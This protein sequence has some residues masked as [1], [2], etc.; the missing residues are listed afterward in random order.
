[1]LTRAEQTPRLHLD[2]AGRSKQ[3]FHWLPNSCL[4]PPPPPPPPILR[5]VPDDPPLTVNF[6]P[7]NKHTNKLACFEQVFFFPS[8][9]FALSCSLLPLHP[10]PSAPN[11]LLNSVSSEAVS[12][13]KSSKLL[14]AQMSAA[15]RLRIRGRRL[16]NSM[17]RAWCTP[18]WSFISSTGKGRRIKA[19]LEQQLNSDVCCPGNQPVPVDPRISWNGRPAPVHHSQTSTPVSPVTHTLGQIL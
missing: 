15:F 17:L 3:E 7:T 14:C 6:S 16:K 5:V 4:E 8:L 12:L 2:T 18:G 13:I 11:K 19:L 9:C 10:R 1:M